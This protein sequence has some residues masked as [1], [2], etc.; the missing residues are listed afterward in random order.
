MFAAT[1]GAYSE[2]AQSGRVLKLLQFQERWLLSGR[3]QDLERWFGIS[4]LR[5]P[6]C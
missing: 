4:K 6:L 2:E 3:R 1:A 5:G